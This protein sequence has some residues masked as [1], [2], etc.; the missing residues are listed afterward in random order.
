MLSK[1]T[2]NC[3]HLRRLM[4]TKGKESSPQSGMLVLLMSWKGYSSSQ[5]TYIPS[6]GGCFSGSKAKTELNTVKENI[7]YI[8]CWIL[9]S[10]QVNQSQPIVAHSLH[11]GN[12]NDSTELVTIQDGSESSPS[13]AQ[14]RFQSVFKLLFIFR[15]FISEYS[16]SHHRIEFLNADVIFQG[17]SYTKYSIIYLSLE[18]QWNPCSCS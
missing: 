8:H 9:T 13:T 17:T 11:G 12:L 15:L 4:K 5:S 14:P 10:Y 16:Q 1:G 3:S 6:K 18:A 7:L 2:I